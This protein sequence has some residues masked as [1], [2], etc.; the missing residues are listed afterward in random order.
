MK[1]P[2][3]TWTYKG[4]KKTH[5]GPYAEDFRDATG[6][7]DGVTIS[8]IDAIGLLM[9]ATQE[10]AKRVKDMEHGDGARA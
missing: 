3:E 10:L 7:G 5:I 1:M 4:E 8:F 2:V 6:V 9:A